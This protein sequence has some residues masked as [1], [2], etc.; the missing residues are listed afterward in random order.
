MCRPAMTMQRSTVSRRG[1]RMAEARRR[2]RLHDQRRES[3]GAGGRAGAAGTASLTSTSMRT[4]DQPI[5]I[6]LV[7]PDGRM[8]TGDRGRGRRR[9]GLRDRP[10]S[11]RRHCRFLRPGGASSE[12][13][14]RGIGQRPDPGRH[15]RSRRSCRPAHRGRREKVAV[16]RAANTSLGVALLAELVERAAARWDPTGTSRSPRPITATRSTRPRARR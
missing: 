12:P 6:S 5:R 15:H 1:A 11:W 2:L 16:L 14:P 8:G 7:A 4:A 9:S 10:G 13:R 3:P